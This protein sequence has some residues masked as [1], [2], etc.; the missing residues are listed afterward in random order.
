MQNVQYTETTSPVFEETT[1]K[2]IKLYKSKNLT[3][4]D[5]NILIGI[6]FCQPKFY[7]PSAW[8]KAKAIMDNL[9]C[10]LGLAFP[11]DY[12]RGK[13]KFSSNYDIDEVKEKIADLI[14]IDY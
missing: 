9:V 4:D 6:G 13:G 2:T 14:A 1:S 11:H 12:G 10:P 7:K 3:R 8:K 5:I